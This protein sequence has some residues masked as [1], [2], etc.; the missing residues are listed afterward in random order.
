MPAVVKAS[1]HCFRNQG[2]GSISW[3]G[4]NS[5]N[6]L[7]TLGV[8]VPGGTF[9]IVSIGEH[10]WGEFE[11]Q[12]SCEQMLKTNEIIFVLATSPRINM[13]TD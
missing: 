4:D 13:I 7:R 11:Y 1:T 2:E 9:I 8:N 3:E 6:W 5:E 10:G 12:I